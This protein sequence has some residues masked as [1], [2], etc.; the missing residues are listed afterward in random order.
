MWI[1]VQKGDG[2]WG[3]VNTEKNND[4]RQHGFVPGIRVP[5][6]EL[7]ARFLTL[8][9]DCATTVIENGSDVKS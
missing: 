2:R 7:E 1:P 9:N 5:W 8:K 3:E 6:P 4:K